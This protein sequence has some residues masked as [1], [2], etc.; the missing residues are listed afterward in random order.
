FSFRASMWSLPEK[1]A[2]SAAIRERNGV[3]SKRVIPRTAERQAR[4]PAA[5]PLTPIPIGVMAPTPVMTTR[6]AAGILIPHSRYDDHVWAAVGAR[7]AVP[8]A[9]T[10][11]PG[12]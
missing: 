3:A 5:S 8:L 4:R 2:T 9:A 12:R 10:D 1:S 6:R 7:H 11:H